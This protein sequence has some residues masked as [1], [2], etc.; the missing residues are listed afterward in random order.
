VPTPA[1]GGARL[2]EK[3]IFRTIE[4]GRIVPTLAG[5][6]LSWGTMRRD[7]EAL[8]RFAGQPDRPVIIGGCPRSGTTLLRTMLHCH[9]ELAIPRETR[10]VVEAWQRRRKFGDLREA[11]N[12]RRLAHWIFKREKTDANRLGLDSEE[13]IERLVAAPPTLGSMLAMCFV[14]FAEKQ[15]KPR[16][17]DKR[18]MYAARMTAIWDLFPN[19]QF[20]HVVRDPRACI[21]SLRKL[22]WYDGH[23]AP[24][25][26][27]WERSLNAV[28]PWRRKLAPDQLLD[29]KYE[30][31]V[32]EPEAT[33]RRVA[34]FAGLAADEVA[35]EQ[36]L[37]Y[38]EFEETRSLR[39]HSNLSRPIDPSRIWGWKEALETPEIAFIEEA[40]RPLMQRWGY[41]AV[42]DGVHAPPE[43]LRD[44]ER[45]RR[46]QTAAHWK[47]AWKDQV[48]KL[49]THRQ[50]L[51]AELPAVAG[52]PGG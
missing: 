4:P 8:S 11:A 26:E 21:A 39:Y 19:A 42:A 50:P 9:P 3:R 33:V 12:R 37:R 24:M 31:L 46:R 22:G 10:F 27:L 51:A 28:D 14:M 5:G 36:M 49:V 44:F 34:A 17:G 38:H 29:V 25:A 48:Q 40:T 41:E 2:L 1:S 45:R 32:L 47:R 35:V 6:L 20:L 18:P 7:A 30:D 52:R 23:I 13:A 15:H 16:W 43:L